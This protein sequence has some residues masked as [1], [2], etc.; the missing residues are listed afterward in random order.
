MVLKIRLKIYDPCLVNFT[1]SRSCDQ[2]GSTFASMPRLSRIPFISFLFFWSYLRPKIKKKKS[3][4]TAPCTLSKRF[5]LFIKTHNSFKIRHD[6]GRR[7]E[8]TLQSEMKACSRVVNQR[9][10]PLAAL[11]LPVRTARERISCSVL[12]GDQQLRRDEWAGSRR[13]IGNTASG[14]SPLKNPFV[15][16]HTTWRPG[17]CLA[18]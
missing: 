8:D 2:Q 9:K 7:A 5:S 10:S 11:T 18:L 3:S 1:E 12:P 13:Q 16:K 14:R 4:L 15:L 17:L 6:S